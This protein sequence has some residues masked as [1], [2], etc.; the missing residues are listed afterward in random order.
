MQT[1]RRRVL[2][3]LADMPRTDPRPT[4]STR[5]HRRHAGP[6]PTCERAA[7]ESSPPLSIK[8]KKQR[9]HI[10]ERD[11]RNRLRPD[12]QQKIRAKSNAGNC[13]PL[14]CR[15]FRTLGV[16]QLKV[17][18]SRGP[19]G[20]VVRHKLIPKSDRIICLAATRCKCECNWLTCSTCLT[21]SLS[22]NICV[23]WIFGT[24]RHTSD[25]G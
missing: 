9:K 23:L 7:A 6:L 4:S 17:F 11:N 24:Q 12:S 15:F 22:P 13:N 2:L 16:L 18:P 19:L 10:L 14:G 5:L 3:A 25:T 8:Q 1:K 20:M 21:L